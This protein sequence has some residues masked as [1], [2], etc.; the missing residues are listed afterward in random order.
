MFNTL[1]KPAAVINNVD[2]EQLPLQGNH[3]SA[4]TAMVCRFPST[5]GILS[6]RS[7]FMVPPFGSAENGWEL[8]DFYFVCSSYCY[9]HCITINY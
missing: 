1:P 5:A 4:V 7:T 8:F 3:G 6:D 2:H 9:C